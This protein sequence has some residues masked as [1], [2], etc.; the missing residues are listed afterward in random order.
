M[1]KKGF[2]LVEVLTVIAILAVLLLIL[3]PNIFSLMEK[4]KEKSCNS[5][6]DNIESAAKMY[7]TNNKYNLGF[8]CSNSKNIDLQTLIDSGDLKPDTTDK[9]TNPIEDKKK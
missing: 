7:V 9:I 6:I 8:T 2:T 4:N 1:N 3:A 5:L